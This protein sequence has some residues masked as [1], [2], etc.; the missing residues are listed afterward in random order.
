VKWVGL[1]ASICHH[2]GMTRLLSL[3]CLISLSLAG[4]PLP[5]PE[6]LQMLLQAQEMK[7]QGRF[8]DALAKLDE[9][10]AVA[11][12][13]PQLS[14]LRGTLYLTPGLRDLDRA[15]RLFD[16]AVARNPGE[17]SSRFHRAE[18]EYVRQDWAAA[19]ARLQQLLVEFP[20]LPQPIRHMV[21]FKRLVCEVKLE[22]LPAA[23][24]TLKDSFTFMDDTPAYYYSQ[25]TLA[26]ARRDEVKAKDWLTRAGG[27]FKP[28]ERSPYEDCLMEA[29]WLPS[30]ALP[31]VS[32]EK[33]KSKG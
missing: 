22:R 26:F 16:E 4:A 31:P 3:F 8:T 12:Q 19:H 29:R 28:A 21:L 11:P 9:V 18:V 7:Q 13:H 5:E 30:L 33:K 2:G 25:A 1:S 24:Q 32:G 14:N 20:K 27:I 10:E 15:A 6:V 23:E 17:F